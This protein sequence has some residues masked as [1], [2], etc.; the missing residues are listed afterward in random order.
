LIIG[1]AARGIPVSEAPAETVRSEAAHQACEDSARAAATH[2]AEAWGDQRVGRGT[3]RE[4]LKVLSFAM[5]VDPT[6]WI[7]VP[8]MLHER[9]QAEERAYDEALK[10][11]LP[12]AQPEPTGPGVLPPPS[13]PQDDPA[14]QKIEDREEAM[15]SLGWPG[16]ADGP[17]AT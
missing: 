5:L 16:P 15:V 3:N 6:A 1:C 14:A 17:S 2:A 4:T 12:S 9:H 7:V 11:C 8:A 10:V 13:P